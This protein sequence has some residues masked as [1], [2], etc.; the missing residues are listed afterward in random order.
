ML[1]G[2]AMW[3][4]RNPGGIP[5][6][7]TGHSLARNS[8]DG[9][10]SSKRL[11]QPARAAGSRAASRGGGPS[12]QASRMN[13]PSGAFGGAPYGAT[14]RC[15]GWGNRMRTAP[16][17]PSAELP[18]GQRNAAPGGGTACEPRHWGIR[19]SSLWGHETLPWVGEP[20]ARPPLTWGDA[21]E[22][23]TGTFG[24]A[25]YGATK[26]C[27]GCGGR[28][29]APPLGPSVELPMGHETL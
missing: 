13:T 27:T 24:G 29:R 23:A 4:G 8:D 16:M 14:K 3:E 1:R 10:G 2:E 7:G 26:R 18:L 20:H 25:P 28:M 9:L 11:R 12:D 22:T 5:P 6:T 21:C 17:G 19:W 15:P